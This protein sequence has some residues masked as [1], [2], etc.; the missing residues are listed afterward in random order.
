M[1][2]PH[3]AP[4]QDW[5]LSVATSLVTRPC[6]FYHSRRQRGRSVPAP[7]KEGSIRDYSSRVDTVVPRTLIRRVE[8]VAASLGLTKRAAIVVILEEGCAQYERRMLDAE[9][10]GQNDS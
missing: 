6:R 10:A 8:Q 4:T 9:A 3:N 1:K 5:R 2:H 7:K